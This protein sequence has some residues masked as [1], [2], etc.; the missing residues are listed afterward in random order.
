MLD[1]SRIPR[2]GKSILI[3]PDAHARPNEDFDGLDRFR[4][5]GKLILD[6]KPDHV[7][8]LG[9]IGD[10]DSLNPHKRKAADAFDGKKVRLDLDAYQSALKDIRSPVKRAN[11]RHRKARRKDR[12]WEPTWNLLEGNHEERW[13]RWPETELLGH[14]ELALLAEEEGWAWT[15]FLDPLDIEGVLFAHY[16]TTGVSRKPAGVRQILNK[17]HRS[18]VWGHTHSWSMDMQPV[19]GGGTLTALCAGCYKPPHRTGEHEWSGLTMLT[20]VRAGSFA[21]QQIPYS[22]VLGRYGEGGYAEQIR[23]ELR[24]EREAAN[25]F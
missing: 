15:R 23:A 6:L 18:T 16:F 5:A 1:F 19:L 8:C 22:H 9:D 4:A 25:A 11:E 3:I 17:T 14:D 13:R 2:P 20:D 12:I 24:D 7:V 21:V 10:F